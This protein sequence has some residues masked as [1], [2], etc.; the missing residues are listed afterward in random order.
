VCGEEIRRKKTYP[1]CHIII[2]ADHHFSHNRVRSIGTP[3]AKHPEHVLDDLDTEN[4]HKVKQT[5]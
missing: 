4:T 3:V 2:G 1:R 5:G